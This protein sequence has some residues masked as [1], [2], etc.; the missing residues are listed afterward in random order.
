MIQVTDNGETRHISS[1]PRGYSHPDL[2]GDRYAVVACGKFW[3]VR[4]RRYARGF[5]KSDQLVAALPSEQE[6][7]GMV[8]FL[9]TRGEA[10]TNG[11]FQMEG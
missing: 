11:V 1:K 2:T 9:R 7:D 3:E 4:L 5:L 8:E 6:A 10:G